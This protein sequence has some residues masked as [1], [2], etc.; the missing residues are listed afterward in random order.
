M[1]TGNSL[2]NEWLINQIYTN[3]G[4]KTFHQNNHDKGGMRKREQVNKDMEKK[5]NLK[6]CALLHC[7]A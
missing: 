4:E 2:I 1:T 3:D 7:D 6:G 5:Y